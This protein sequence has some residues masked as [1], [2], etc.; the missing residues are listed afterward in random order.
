MPINIPKDL[1]A[2]EILESEKIFAIDDSDASKQ[3]IRPLKLV[4]LNLMPKKIETEAQILRLISKSPLQVDIDFMM[5]KNHDS[6]NTSHDHLVKFYDFFDHLK[7]NYY[8]G[9]I[10][11]GAPVEHLAFEEVDYWEELK[12]IMEW[13]KTHVFSTIH[14]C[15]GAQ[16]GL[17]YHYDIAKQLLPEKV[18]G[19]FPER[20]VDEYDFLT[21][22]FDEIHYTPHSRHTA[23]DTNALHKVKQLSILS[24][25]EEIGPNII[26]TKDYR[27]I[28][29]IGHFEYSKDTL[30][31]EYWRDVHLGKPIHI[32]FNYFPDDDPN[33]EP[34]LKWR[35]HANL[36]YR[37]WLNYVYQVTPYMIEKIA[38]IKEPIGTGQ[39]EEHGYSRAF[40]K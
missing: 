8:D 39:K 10:I 6:K 38:E 24:E 9:M 36:L 7:M 25:N 12:Q 37:N 4:I 21:N 14:I 16:A 19:I 40:R 29:V 5:V 22:G 33:K 27:Q 30:A 11:T 26:V 1:P 2:K 31:Q 13:S 17:Y 35:S 20:L 23:I 15:W 28:F 32:P 18:F 3:D 34:L